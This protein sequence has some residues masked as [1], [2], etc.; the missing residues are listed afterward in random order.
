[1][2][3]IK[4]LLAGVLCVFACTCFAG[5]VASKPE[6]RS[7]ESE[8]IRAELILN[9][10]GQLNVREV[11]GKNDGPEV[12]KYLAHVGFKKGAPWCAAFVAW[13]LNNVGVDNPRTAWSPSYANQKDIIW[14]HKCDKKNQVP[15]PGDVF[16]LYYPNLKRV[17]HVGFFIKQEGNSAI[18]IEGNTNGAG[19]R[20]GD[21]VY[22]KRR[23]LDKVYAISRYI[24]THRTIATNENKKTYSKNFNPGD[25]GWLVFM[26]EHPNGG[27]KYCYCRFGTDYRS[28]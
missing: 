22:R 15:L 17:G 23:P 24:G 5:D 28:C 18:T 19:S 3:K 4:I 7:P 8:V 12:E 10:H 2:H 20:E 27:E 9:L 13:N 6:V 14:K 26:P 16:S 25:V 21:G 1:M 11:T